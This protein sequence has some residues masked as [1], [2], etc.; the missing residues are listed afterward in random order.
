MNPTSVAAWLGVIAQL[1]VLGKTTYEE[2]AALFRGPGG[3]TDVDTAAA[4]NAQ[5]EA[6]RVLIASQREKAR[7]E[8]GSLLDPGN[9]VGG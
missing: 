7:I 2:V 3:E 1:I 9:G 6:L 4:D 8:A 5:L